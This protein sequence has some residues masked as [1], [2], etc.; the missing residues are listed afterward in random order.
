MKFLKKEIKREIHNARQRFPAFNSHHEAYAVIK[1]EVDELWDCIKENSN[2]TDK[3]D[4]VIQII[5]MCYCYVDEI[6]IDEIDKEI[7]GDD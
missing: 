6:L 7:A 1:E 3:F 4:E 2:A 5:S